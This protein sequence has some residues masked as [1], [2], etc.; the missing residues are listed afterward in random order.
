[1]NLT[2]I[3]SIKER[4]AISS[5]WKPDECDFILDCINIAIV[6]ENA[7]LAERTRCAQIAEAVDSGRGNEKIIIAAILEKKP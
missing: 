2:R 4:I 7:V 3:I 6:S 1:M 5:E